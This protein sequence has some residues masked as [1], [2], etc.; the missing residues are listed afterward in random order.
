MI[1]L[2]CRIVVMPLQDQQPE[3]VAPEATYLKSLSEDR[4]VVSV[5]LRDG[6]TVHGWIE[7][8]DCDM[9]R[10]TRQGSPNIFIYKHDILYIAEEAAR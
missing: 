5:K 6:D 10:L 2:R 3:V 9:L 7:Y 4:T 8:Y 1:A